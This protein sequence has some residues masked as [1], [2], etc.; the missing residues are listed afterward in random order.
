MPLIPKVKLP[1]GSIN[2][3]PGFYLEVY[4]LAN[5]PQLLVIGTV[6]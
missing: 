3:N 4:L 1:L 2:Y 5:C 6:V